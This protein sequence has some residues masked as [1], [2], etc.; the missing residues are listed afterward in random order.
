MQELGDIVYTVKPGDTLSNIGTKYGVSYQTIA[1]TNMLDDPD[2]IEVGQELL[3]PGASEQVLP[4]AP[5]I[6]AV[7]L[8]VAAPVAGTIF[9]VNKWYVIGGISVLVVISYFII[10]A[11]RRSVP[12]K[13]RKK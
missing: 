8:P 4:T 10:N 9:G 13:K 2:I 1:Q 3:I 12:I 5:T 6:P 11:G 7:A